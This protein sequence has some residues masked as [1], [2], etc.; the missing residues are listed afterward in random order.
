[1]TVGSSSAIFACGAARLGLRVAFVGV[2]GDD[3]F[4]R[5]ML[6]AM[7]GRGIDV[8]ACTVD[9]DR[10]TGA[11]VVL[12][13]GRD[14]AILTAMG[15]IGRSTSTRCRTR[16]LGRARHLHSSCF[17]LQDTSRDRLPAF[18]AAARARGLTTSFDTNWDPTGRWDGGVMEMLAAC[19]V[20]LPNEAEACRI[21]ARD[22]VEDAA[23]EL[24]RIGGRDRPSR[25]RTDRG[26]QAR[27]EG[28]ARRSDRTGSL[29]SA[30]RR[31]PSTPVDT[32]GAG[33]SFDAGF[34]RAWL[35]GASIA[36][37]LRLGAVCGALSTLGRG[38]VDAQPT[39]AEAIGGHG[40]LDLRMTEAQR[41]LF[42]AA[43]PSID[44]L[45]RGGRRS[46][47]GAIHRPDG[48]LA[49][50]GGKGLNAA[51]A[52]VALGA[53]VTAMA[54]V[55]GQAGEWIAERL[56]ETGIDAALVRDGGLAETRTCLSVLDRST[57]RLTE[58]YEPG[59]AIQPDNVAGVRGRAC[60]PS[61]TRATSAAVVCSGSLPPGAPDDAYARIV[62]L[63][64]P[65]THDRR[66]ARRAAGAGASRSTR[67]SSR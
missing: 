39:H 33:D 35:D 59:T 54:I 40:P 62:R 41:I 67:R 15:T 28:R 30:S 3:P 50:P 57:G 58:F 61:S 23:R 37:A 24:A 17:F 6:E 32:T 63:A 66:R 5:F 29:E 10:P 2:V 44:R 36:D 12:T 38:G 7:A 43:N 51:R 4:G 18:M 14:R 19:D 22:D 13:S 53:R 34:L 64:A 25:R 42:V 16:M 60:G 65:T 1:M 46:T 11:T 47:V 31:S 56:A 45:A 9:P 8:S 48:V 55:G 52:A 20:F 49:V 26:R 27:L 21:A